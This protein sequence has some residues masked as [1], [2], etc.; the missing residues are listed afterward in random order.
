MTYVMTTNSQGDPEDYRKIVER[1]TD[2]ADGLIAR[3]AGMNDAGLA[4]TTV[5]ESKA[6]SDRFT[7]EH[8]MP[9]VR[10]IVGA[11]GGSGG[12]TMIDFEA[13]DV[14]LRGA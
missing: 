12:G 9:A 6:H 13:F 11:G 2:H 4:I 10:E 5:W 3:Y 14:D 7:T 8:L 1:V